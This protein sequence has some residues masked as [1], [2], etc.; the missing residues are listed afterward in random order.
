M[1]C[2]VISECYRRFQTTTDGILN[3]GTVGLIERAFGVQIGDFERKN[4]ILR[5]YV[6][7][8]IRHIVYRSRNKYLALAC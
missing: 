3:L 1:N 5:N 7:F 6:N 8:C 4:F 2:E